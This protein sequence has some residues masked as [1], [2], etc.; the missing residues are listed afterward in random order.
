MP[1]SPGFWSQEVSSLEVTDCSSSGWPTECDGL[2]ESVV[3]ARL[4]APIASILKLVTLE[5]IDWLDSGAQSTA[6]TN[7]SSCR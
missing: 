4:L 3:A 7:H 1:G 5:S 6:K 2:D